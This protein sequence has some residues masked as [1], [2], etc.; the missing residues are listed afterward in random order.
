MNYLHS[1][2]IKAGKIKNSDL[3]YTLSVF[4]LEPPRWIDRYEW[5]SFTDLELCASGTYWKYVGDAM[6][7]SMDELPSYKAGWTDGLHWLK[8][9][10]TWSTKYEERHMVAAKTNNKLAL[11]HLDLM[12]LNVPNRYKVV[13]Q[14]FVSVIVGERLRQAMM[15]PNAPAIYHQT[16]T[17]LL[18][19][20]QLILRYL[21]FPRPEILRK[22]YLAT[23]NENTGKYNA[24]EYLSHPWYVKPSFRRRWGP[25]ALCTRFL[26]RKVP[27]D[28]GNKYKPEGFVVSEVGPD[29]Q[30]GKG[31][32]NMREDQNR[33]RD[34][35]QDGCPFSFRG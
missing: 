14:K 25:R 7:I 9:M 6:N 15:L 34:L 8:E 13:C 2:Y 4:A 35:H 20:R 3:L 5:R 16:I 17:L 21:T 1:Q 19:S 28:E 22:R 23:Y 29:F 31:T 11:A 26:G 24:Q 32:T 33:I 12:F 30:R 10:E 27:G 18:R